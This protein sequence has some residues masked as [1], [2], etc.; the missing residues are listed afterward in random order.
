MIS[1]STAATSRS[2]GGDDEGDAEPL[3]TGRL[4]GELG[5]VLAHDEAAPREHVT[6]EETLERVEPLLEQ[7]VAR[8]I[9]EGD[10]EQRHEI[11]HRR[12]GQCGR[13]LRE[14]DAPE[15]GD[16]PA[17]ERYGTHAPRPYK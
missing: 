3:E 11:Q 4:R 15:A 2:G 5:E 8:D 10:R 9:D 14:A 17:D 12:I 13:R 16:D 6:E 7:R 1:W